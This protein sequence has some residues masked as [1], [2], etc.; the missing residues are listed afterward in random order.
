MDDRRGQDGDLTLVGWLVR[1]GQGSA[2]RPFS[3]L[4]AWWRAFQEVRRQWSLSVDQAIAGGFQADRV[5][6]AFAAGYLIYSISA[7]TLGIRLS[8][9]QQRRGADLSIH[10]I[11]S[12]PELGF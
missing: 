12:S 7:R 5:G 1:G 8:D 6:Y 9:E 11:G 3:D 4:R 10:S 2:L